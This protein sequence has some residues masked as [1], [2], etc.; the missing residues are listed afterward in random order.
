[1]SSDTASLVTAD[2]AADA[3]ARSEAGRLLARKHRR[4]R[5]AESLRTRLDVD[6]RTRAGRAANALRR[7]LLAHVGPT[8]TPA[9]LAM[10]QQIV[11]LKLRLVMMDER[12][13]L[14]GGDVS[15]HDARTYLAWS[16]G[17]TR[18]LKALGLT[19]GAEPPAP[20]LAEA[21][22]QGAEVALG[23]RRGAGPAG[24]PAP[25]EGHPGV[26]SGPP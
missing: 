26:A 12:F 15:A 8:P 1:M 20:T 3:S 23:G 16:N 10:V 11:Q 21:L 13:L 5:P 17:F 2:P 18:A 4:R 19:G 7:A 25:T 6:C 24:G 22:A 9:Q 14:S